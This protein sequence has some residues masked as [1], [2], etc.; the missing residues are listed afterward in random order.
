MKLAPVILFT[1]SRPVHTQ[2]ILDSLAKN[3]ESKYSTLYVY[4]DGPKE[5]VSRE[6]LAKIDEVR[7][8]VKSETRF[9]QVIIKIQPQNKGLAPSIIQGVS[10][11]INEHGKA[12]VLEDDLVLS[13]YFLAYMNDSLI[14]YEDNNKVGQ[15]G[16][17][18]FFANGNKFPDRFFIPIPD[19]LGWATWK[20]RW[21]HFNPNSGEL[22]SLLK[23]NPKKIEI[24]N[25]YNSFDFI[26]M[27]KMQMEGKVSS[28]AIRWQAVCVLKGWQSLYPNLSMSNHLESTNTD[29]THANVN[30][31]PPLQ[32]EAPE[33]ETIECMEIDS[34]IEAMKLG[35][36]GKGDYFGNRK[37]ESLE[38][39]KYRI[40]SKIKKGIIKFLP[41]SV[42]N[43]IKKQLAKRENGKNLM[44]SGNYATWQDAQKQCIGYDD[45]L[46]LETCKNALLKVKNGEAVY[47]RD[48]VIFDKI[49]YS[50]AL[51]ATL[52]KAA[53]ENNGKLC[54]LDFG[55]SLGST[56][57]QNKDFLSAVQEL[58]WCIVEQ[59]HFVS[60]G[61]ENFENE[62]LRFYY[63]IEECLQHHQPDVILLSGVL[64]YLE[65]PHTWMQKFIKLNASYIII[66]RTAVIEGHRDMLTIQK[67]PDSIY[68]ASYPCWLFNRNKLVESVVPRYSLTAEDADFL[69]GTADIEGIRAKWN[70][71]LFKKL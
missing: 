46:I 45:D 22:L 6:V 16:A 33:F 12:I 23:A 59:P 61:R 62:Q 36:S 44:W 68:A 52:A 38:T 64:S 63:S 25:A 56:Y 41:L 54:V 66:D 11:V 9:Q 3:A 32:E 7:E 2:Q 60:C 48:S 10:D 29:A 8:I 1:Y 21:E 51:S 14:R 40:K 28:W 65:D 37:A 24:F 19:C 43:L 70:I 55:G 5:N 58:K 35:Y 49:Q 50:W 71:F 27:L 34:V 18:N 31:I 20:N 15:I 53:L 17:C 42:I 4:C 69:G 57:Y 13:P 30:I 26:G 39:I 47:E 67:V